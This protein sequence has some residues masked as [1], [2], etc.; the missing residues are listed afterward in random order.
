MSQSGNPSETLGNV[1]HLI[2]R[3]FET[4]V[5]SVYL[6]EPDRA[7]LVLAATIGLRPESVGRVRMRLT[8][9]L[10]G[11][12]AE[13]LRPQVVAD[14][15][16]HPRFKYFREAGEDAV[17]LVSRRADHR[18][19][20]AAGRAG[21]ADR[22]SRAPSAQDDVRMLVTAGAQVAPIVSEARALGQFVAPAQRAAAAAGAEPVVEL[23]QRNDQPVPRAR[24]GRVAGAATTTRS[25]CCSRCRSSSSRSARCAAGPAQPDQLRLPPA[26]RSISTPTHTWGARHAGVLWARPVAYFSAE[27]GL[28][29]SMPIYSGGLGI[30]AGDHL[31]S[32]SDLGIPLVG[33]GLYYDQGYFRQRLDAGRLAARGLPRRRQPRAADASR[34]LAT[35]R[36]SPSTIETR[37]GTIAARVWKLAVGRSTLLLLD[38][39][40]DGNRPEDRELTAR[41]YGGDDR[42]R[43]RQELLLGVGGV[44]A[45]AALGISPG[46]V[47][48]NEGHSAFAA[49]ELVRQRMEAEGI[50]AWEAHA[51]RRAAGRLHHAHAGA[52]RARSLFARARSRSTSGRSRDALGLEHR[53]AS[54][55]SAATHPTTAA[56]AS[57]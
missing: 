19:R 28:H 33:V 48:L 1:V 25:R 22:P 55:G 57:A 7:N 39:N 40:V 46:V 54:W 23:G 53:S 8:E 18:S 27:F 56:R 20:P 49:L 3:R 30:L 12:V 11:L 42:V 38:S 24:S 15:T 17:P 31:K 35:A 51:P 43:I 50:D 36:R 29:E 14:A 13:Q 37:T 9:G 45:L 32:A 4:D 10:A 41:L 44:R 16:T 52:R 34:R 47:H 5:C 21:R 26:C 2:Q 6:L